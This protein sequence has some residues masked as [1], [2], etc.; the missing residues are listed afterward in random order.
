MFRL[1]EAKV[2]RGPL[3]VVQLVLAVSVLAIGHGQSLAQ[4]TAAGTTITNTATVAYTLGSDPTPLSAAAS[5]SFVVLETI[6]VVTV[7]Q[8]AANVPVNSP[9]S[10]GVLTFLLTNTGNGPEAF[11]LT[12]DSSISGDDFDPSVQALWLETNGTPGLQAGGATPDTQYQPGLNDPNL[13]A[14]GSASIYLL[15]DIPGSLADGNIGRV[16]L[17]AAALTPGAAGASAGTELVGAGFNGVN[18]VVGANQAE[19]DALG[20][21]EIASVQV[22]LTKSIQQVLDPQG[23]NQPCTGARVTY[24]ILVNVSGGGTAQLLEITDAVPNNMTYVPGT[25][26][27]NGNPQTDAADAPVDYSDFN[28]THSNTVTVYLGDTA[29]PAAQ[30]IDFQTTIN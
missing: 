13:A 17:N 11:G 14:D 22:T 12:T 19:G 20:A 15:S 1:K 23:G 30:T 10:N 4:G 5:G 16:R 26:M 27:L 8:D 18:A 28:V 6:D 25:I 3:R 24:R 2:I 29:A 21:Y 7:W 9:H